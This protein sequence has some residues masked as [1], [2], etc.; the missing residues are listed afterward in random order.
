MHATGLAFYENRDEDLASRMRRRLS[1]L[2]IRDWHSYLDLL[3]DPSKG[4]P[5]L[6]ALVGELTIG[7]TYFFRYPEHFETLEEFLLPEIIQRNQSCRQL[8][9]WSAGC[10]TGAEAYS[11]SL[12]LKRKF[13]L[14]IAGWRVR[15]VG[16]DINRTFLER[17]E[18]G[19]FSNMALRST[20]D[21]IK[22]SCFEREDSLWSIKPE[23][24]R[25]VSFEYHNLVRHSFP[26]LVHNLVAFDLILCRNVMI[27]FSSAVA[28]RVIK[29]FWDSLAPGGWLLVGHAEHNPDLFR[30]FRTHTGD[31]GFT[32]YQRP[33][34][35]S[36]LPQ[37]AIAGHWKPPVVSSAA[38]VVAARPK[39]MPLSA[40][41][42]K[43]AAEPASIVDDIRSYNEY[44]VFN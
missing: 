23:Y 38:T 25:D 39:D 19:K 9:V 16:T 32:L 41:V 28:Q 15:I 21:E 2:N 35:A 17:A 18:S 12:L 3:Q 10:S 4:R 8:R 14:S 34:A 37:V 1:C 5:E 27:Y 33:V 36:E 30:G 7:E 22:A 44:M 13:A 43:A 26:S 24:K 31:N 11:V 6:D 20:P 42:P 40:H 29:Q